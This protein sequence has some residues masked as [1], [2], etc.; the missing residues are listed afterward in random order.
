MEECVKIGMHVGAV[1]RRV[2]GVS[3]LFQ[4]FDKKKVSFTEY[5]LLK[6][7]EIFEAD[8]CRDGKNDNYHTEYSHRSR[9]ICSR[10]IP[11]ELS[12]LHTAPF[13]RG[14]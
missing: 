3:E 11:H 5:Y 13:N 6:D 2:A 14:L 4:N 8:R 10:I 7:T 1:A 9:Y 12:Y